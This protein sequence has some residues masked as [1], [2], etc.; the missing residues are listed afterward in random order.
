MGAGAGVGA[1]RHAAPS[2][3]LFVAV[4][5]PSEARAAISGLV[6]EVRGRVDEQGRGV[7]WVRL[8]GLHLTL[9]FLGPTHETRQGA[10]EVALQEAATDAGPITVEVGG[11]GAFPTVERPRVL[12]LGLTRG[13]EALRTVSDTLE[14]N[15]VTAGWPPEGRPFRPHLSLA[16]ADGVRSGPATAAALVDAAASFSTSFTADRLTLFE[17]HT[18][19]GPARYEPILEASLGG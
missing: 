16:R 19:A 14:A 6:D 18:G 5:L 15:L 11:A 10:V 4:A 1:V 17:S 8:D 13:A 2:H 9:R 12:W 7:R 3:R